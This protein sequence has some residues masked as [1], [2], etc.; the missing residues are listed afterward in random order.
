M[1][2]QFIINGI[3][4]GVLYSLA[5]AGFALVYNTTR[6]FH[7]AA[8]AVYTLAAYGFFF[9]ARSL[10]LPLWLAVVVALVFTAAASVACETAVYRPLARKGASPN[11]VMISSIGLMTILINVVAMLFGNETKIIS[12]AIQTPFRF[13]GLVLTQPQ[14]L[15]LV[16]GAGALALLAALLKFS[17]LGIKMRALGN[18]PVLYEIFGFN[19]GALRLGVFALSGVFLGLSSCLSANDVGMTPYGGMS[20]L[21]NAFVAMIIG[22][23]ERI[24]ACVAG[25][26]LLGVLQALA[27]WQFAANW[28][29]AVTFLLLLVF[30]FFRPQGLLGAR[31]RAV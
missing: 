1:F 6:I 19:T 5:A 24:L 29:N 21:I 14:M 23:T 10:G 22:G 3:I 15:Q 11:V 17:S 18:A 26:I 31:R 9:A 8:A 20:V 27:V 4:T 25:G 28:Q 16:V 7:I 2:L 12:N 13:G 30:L